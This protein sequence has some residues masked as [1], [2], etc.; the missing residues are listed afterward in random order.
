MLILHFLVF[1]IVHAIQSFAPVSEDGLTDHL[2]PAG[3]EGKYNDILYG[4]KSWC[5]NP[6][7]ST[8]YQRAVEFVAAQIG[9]VRRKSCCNRFFCCTCFNLEIAYPKFVS[10]GFGSRSL[11]EFAE[12]MNEKQFFFEETCFLEDD[13]YDPDVYQM[14][15]TCW[16]HS[17]ARL[18]R[19]FIMKIFENTISM[20]N[21][22]PFTDDVQQTLVDLAVGG[23]ECTDWHGGEIPVFIHRV[24]PMI[25][26]LL[27]IF[28]QNLNQRNVGM[29]WMQNHGLFKLIRSSKENDLVPFTHNIPAPYAISEIWKGGGRHGVVAFEQFEGSTST[30]RAVN[31]QGS[32]SNCW[33]DRW[34][35]EY[36]ARRVDDYLLVDLSPAGISIKRN[37]YDDDIELSERTIYGLAFGSDDAPDFNHLNSHVASLH[38]QPEE[39]HNLFEILNISQQ[40]KDFAFERSCARDKPSVVQRYIELGADVNLRTP[41]GKTPL[42]SAAKRANLDNCNFLIDQGA[43]P[44]LVDDDNLSALD[45]AIIGFSSV[46]WEDDNQ[47]RRLRGVVDLFADKCRKDQLH[48]SFL[49]FTQHPDEYERVLHRYGLE[50]PLAFYRKVRSKRLTGIFHMDAGRPD[51]APVLQKYVN[52]LGVD[53]N[54]LN[55]EGVTALHVSASNGNLANCKMLISLGADVT[56]GSQQPLQGAINVFG[57]NDGKA[58]MSELCEKSWKNDEYKKI[59]TLLAKSDPNLEEFKQAFIQ[60]AEE[61][62][63]MEWPKIQEILSI[64]EVLR[65]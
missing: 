52:N 19:A 62:S 20:R 38:D 1:G 64:F 35:G 40:V 24:G 15:G 56:I 16:A 55:H 53:I 36:K 10:E 33:C 49:R 28:A 42:M 57:M 11:Q 26:A 50:G 25:G 41:T 32:S 60:R 65:K 6:F 7:R 48:K 61:Q 34:T 17:S 45:H 44:F 4:E 3:T 2:H 21:L 59:I 51:A 63:Q 14:G 18:L 23:W 58:N 39:L 43:D 31:S 47:W 13:P 9:N 29:E 30:W 27:V 54:L 5:C 12:E 46:Y 22:L 37:D 8:P